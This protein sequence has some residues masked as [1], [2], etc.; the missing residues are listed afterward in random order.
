[1]SIIIILNYLI[2]IIILKKFVNYLLLKY[3]FK[4]FCRS[5]SKFTELTTATVSFSGGNESF[6]SCNCPL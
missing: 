3:T 1:M 5:G 4:S 6:F 2:K